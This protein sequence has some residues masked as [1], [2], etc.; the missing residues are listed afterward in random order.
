MPDVTGEQLR[1]LRRAEERLRLVAES[2]DE[3]ILVASADLSAVEYVTPAYEELYGQPVEALYE[4][5]R[6]FLESVHPED[7]ETYEADVEAML[8]DFE[9]DDPRSVYEGEYRLRGD[10]GE[11][12]RWRHVSRYPVVEGD[13]DGEGTVER[14]VAVIE[15]VTERREFERAYRELFENVSDGLVVHDPETGE[16][17]D[18][19]ERF[20]GMNGYERDELVGETVDVVTATGEG[21]S[22]EAAQQ[23]ISR[24]DEA[25]PQLF[26]WRNERK[27][28]STFPVEVHL[29]IVEIRGEERVLASVRDVTER[30]R[31][32]R[33]YE[34]I[35]DGV[36]DAITVHDPET[37]ELVRVN[38]SLCELVGYDR[39]TVLELGTEG[40]SATDQ[41][42]TAERAREVIQEV[43][44]TGESTQAE[45]A[46]ETADEIC[47]E[48]GAEA[49]LEP[50][51]GE[52]RNAEWF[53]AEP[54]ILSNQA[55]TARFDPIR[56]DHEPSLHPTFP[57]THAEAS[58]RVGETATRIVED[59]AG[60][61]LL[62]GHGLTVG[63]VVEGLVGSTAG[64]DAPLCGITRIERVAERTGDGTDEWEL[65]CSGDTSHL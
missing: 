6:S 7:R 24:A 58:A 60:T 65:D 42:F 22:Y 17:L 64:V 44:E 45:W 13:E 48:I 16:I 2:V 8:A 15:D 56:D 25:G 1:E 52:H 3:V 51:L 47:R 30:K 63:G 34:Q 59:E 14:F 39:E 4:R 28:G 26:E 32:E 36:N 29:A 23:H 27:D 57:E 54:E 55:L 33:E 40:I 31:R 62:V 9:R 21:Y 35:F 19:N 61:V 53:D 50:G 41:G 37:G 43:V 38:D 20:C 10:E 5:P 18:A 11:R 12:P 46:V 49:W